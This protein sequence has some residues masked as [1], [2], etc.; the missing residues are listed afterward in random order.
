MERVRIRV[1]QRAGG[2][3]REGEGGGKKRERGRVWTSRGVEV[4]HTC[5]QSHTHTQTIGKKGRREGG[6]EPEGGR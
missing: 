3:E 6:R 4:A 5:T 1:G 2:G